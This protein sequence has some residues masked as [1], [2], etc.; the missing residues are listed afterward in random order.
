MGIVIQRSMI[1]IVNKRKSQNWHNFVGIELSPVSHTEKAVSVAGGFLGIYSI[2]QI[3][4][5][6]VGIEAATLIVAS[7]GAS[8][9]LLFAVP[10][11]PL[12]Q[13]WPWPR[14]RS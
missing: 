4:L 5:Y 7:I 3:S 14:F 8:A 2:L 9:V 1:G 10:H 12:S 6:F 11:G 13:P